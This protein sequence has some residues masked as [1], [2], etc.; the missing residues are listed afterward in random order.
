MDWYHSLWM[1]PSSLGWC[2]A[3]LYRNRYFNSFCDCCQCISDNGCF[4]V[5]LVIAVLVFGLLL[6]FL[7]L[8]YKADLYVWCFSV[9][10]VLPAHTPI[11]SL[12]R[13][14]KFCCWNFTIA[15]IVFC[16]IRSKL[17][18]IFFATKSKINI[19][20]LLFA[21]THNMLQYTSLNVSFRFEHSIY[22]IPWQSIY[23]TGKIY[24]IF[25]YTHYSKNL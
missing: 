25:I 20:N 1:L 7:C 16:L 18:S 3:E 21:L 11:R 10:C 22:F 2:A 8:A 9:Y 23:Y 6:P 19:F 14:C 12:C 15:N 5:W 13:R 17:F 24:V 4:C